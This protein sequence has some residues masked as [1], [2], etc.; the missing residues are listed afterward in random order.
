MKNK[1][2]KNKLAQQEIVGFVLIVVLVV[3]ALM[4]YL[5]ITLRTTEKNEGSLEVTNMLD[6]IMK[7]T[8][9]CAIVYVPDYDNFEDLFK[10]SYN[11]ERC[12]NLN[13]LAED[14]L[15]EK[16]KEVLSEIVK[17]EAS[18]TGYE[19]RFYV[20]EENRGLLQ[21]EEGNCTSSTKKSAKRTLASG[22]ER[23]D[24]TL[25]LCYI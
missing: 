9:N 20:R 24:I 18:V 3:V 23:L 8:T 12:R 22:S 13:I 15:E 10:S 21:I 19:L 5:T 16:I 1:F 17:S 2:R 6:A 11:N 7:Q 25:Q 4:I 14:Y